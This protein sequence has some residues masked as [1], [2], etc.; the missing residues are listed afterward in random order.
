M[1]KIYNIVFNS[2]WG[3]PASSSQTEYFID[4]SRLPQGQYKCSF[5]FV[6]TNILTLVDIANV[7]INLGCSNN[8]MATNPTNTTIIYNYNYIGSLVPTGIGNNQR[9]NADLST[10]PP[11]YLNSR[12]VSNNVIVYIL[13]NNATQDVY[14]VPPVQEVYTLTLNLELLD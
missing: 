7:F 1:G 3:L 5:T 10:N 8:F 2:Q 12:P 4:W 13:R 6:G 9:L 11:F 14:I